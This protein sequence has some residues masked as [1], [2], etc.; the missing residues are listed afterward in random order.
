M[1]FIYWT[2]LN[3]FYFIKNDIT[4]K[5]IIHNKFIL[6]SRIEMDGDFYTNIVLQTSSNFQKKS[7]EKL[8]DM[9]IFSDKEIYFSYLKYWNQILEFGKA[10]KLDKYNYFNTEN[11][12]GTA[13][14][15]FYPKRRDD[16]KR[17]KDDIKK[18]LKGIQNPQSATIKVAHGKW[19]DERLDILEELKEL[20]SSGASIQLVMNNDVH[21]NT[22]A[23]LKDL[24]EGVHILKKSISMHT[25]FLIIEEGRDRMVITG[26]HNMTERSLRESFEII[27]SFQNELLYDSYSGYF[28]QIVSLQNSK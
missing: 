15:Y 19:D 16:Q 18:I 25:K 14:V 5:G 7:T 13:K 8:Q 4:K 23:E 27:I 3:F 21:K 9:V 2:H 11:E 28:N 12:L 17:G 1:H 24:G 10:E 26:S 6:F 22:L 20:Q